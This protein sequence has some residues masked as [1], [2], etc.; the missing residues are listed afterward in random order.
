MSNPSLFSN[1]DLKKLE[2][3][4]KLSQRTVV[5]QIARLTYSMAR[6]QQRCRLQIAMTKLHGHDI[7]YCCH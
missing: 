7:V 2:C 4:L 5:M 1:V 6:Y 3:L